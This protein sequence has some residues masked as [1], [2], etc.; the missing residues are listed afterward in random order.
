MGERARASEEGSKPESEKGERK[1]GSESAAARTRRGREIQ[2]MC[3]RGFQ[4]PSQGKPLTVKGPPHGPIPRVGSCGS[5]PTQ[6]NSH[7]AGSTFVLVCQSRSSRLVI[8][9]AKE[10]LYARSPS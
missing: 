2:R 4:S 1:P 10:D 6:A 5:S 8:V 7:T 3:A 9:E